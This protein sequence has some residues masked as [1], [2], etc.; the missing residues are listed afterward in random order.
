MISLKV[1]IIA[2]SHPWWLRLGRS[3]VNSNVMIPALLAVSSFCHVVMTSYIRKARCQWASS[4][5][6]WMY[7]YRAVAL[8]FSWINLSPRLYLLTLNNCTELLRGKFPLCNLQLGLD[9]SSKTLMHSIQAT[10]VC[11]DVDLLMLYYQL[12]ICLFDICADILWVLFEVLTAMTMKNEVFWDVASYRSCVQT[13]ATCSHWFLVRRF[14]Y[15]EDGGDMFLRNDGSY[16][17][18]GATS[19]KTVFLIIS[20][21]I[22]ILYPSTFA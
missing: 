22:L 20:F 1:L 14:F 19:Q 10:Y 18:H 17:L 6:C 7:C 21:L 13:A 12:K 8:P 4:S 16:N 15:P 3:S 2:C 5:D 9:Y 11:W